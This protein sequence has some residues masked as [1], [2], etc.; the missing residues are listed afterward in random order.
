VKK[1]PGIVTTI[2]LLW[3]SATA[4]GQTFEIP[5]QSSQPAQKSPAAKSRTKPAQ[6]APESGSIGWGNSIEVGRTARAAEDAMKRGNFAAAANYAQR[7][8]QEAPGNAKLWFLLGY[9]S[10]MAGQISQSV[11]AYRK[12]LAREPNSPDGLSGLAQTYAKSGNNGEA[13]RIL[14]QVTNANPK[15]VNDLL[16]LGE[17]YIKINDLQQGVQVLQRA[18]SQ[19]PSAHSELLMAMAYMRLKEPD[20]A[21]QLLDAAKRRAPNNPEIF[22]A[23]A[24]Y[25]REEHDYKGAIETLKSVPHPTPDVWAD[26]GYSYELEGDK[27]EAANAYGQAANAQP[28]EIKFQLSAAQANLNA[29][30]IDDGKRYLARAAAIDANSYRLHA[31]RAALAKSEDRKQD[32]INE[33]NFALAHMSESVPEGQLYPI[34]LR[35]NLA[36]L[37][38]E[39]GDDSNAQQ[40]L[41]IAEQQMAR[42]NVEGPAKAEFLRVRA[43]IKMSRQDYAGAETDLKDALGID[44]NNTNARLQ[45]GSLLWKVGRKDEAKK[46][47]ADVLARDPNNRYAMESLGYLA[48]DGGDIKLAEEWFNKLATAYPTDYVPHLA[49]GDL[50][51]A[52]RDFAKAEDDYQHAY[53]LAPKNAI[54][55]ANAANAAIEARKFDSAGQWLARA[56]GDMQN[57]PKVMLERERYLFHVGKFAE[58]AELG[59]KVLTQLP[60]DRNASVYLGYALYDLGRYDDVLALTAKYANVLPKEPNF[61]LLAGHVHKQSQLLDEA[62]DDYTHAIERDPKMVEAYINRGYVYNDL[63]NAEQA[64]EDFDVALKLTPNNGIA[65]LGLAFADLQLHKGKSAL[66]HAETAAKLMGDSGAVHLARATAYRQMRLLDKAEKEYEVALKYAP[67]DLRLNLALADTLY[68]LRRYNDSLKVL[69]TAMTLSPD[70][71][72]I[73][74][75]MAHATAELH[76][77][78]RTLQYVQQAERAGADQSSVLLATG[79]ALL[80]LGDREGAMQRFSRALDT[81]DADKVDVRLAIARVFVKQGKWDDAKQQIALAFAESRIGEAAPVTADNLIEAANTFLAMN[82]FDLAR[83][84]YTRA[85][86]MGASDEVVA[87]GLANTYL[88]TGHSVDALHQLETLGSAADNQESYDYTLALANVYRQQHDNVR[89]LTALARANQLGGEDPVAERELTEVAGDEGLRLND[90]FSVLTN[91]DVAPI[92]DDETIYMLDAKLF[93]VVNSPSQL[94]PPRSSTQMA[95]TNAYRFHPGGLPTV[96]GFFQIRNSRGQ[97]S[98]PSEAL[99]LDRNTTDYALNSGINPV[100]HLGRNTVQ[101]NTGLQFTVRRDA[102]SKTAA[103]E[104]NQNLFRQFLYVS[105]NSFFNW[106]AVRGNAF[107]ESGPFT[108]RSLN[109]R[110]LGARLEFVVGRPWGR[111]YMVTGYSNRDL[112]FHPLVREFFSTSTY[113]GIEHRFGEHLKLT[114]VGEYIRSWRVQDTSWVF[115]QAMRPA[116]SLQYQPTRR[117]LVDAD[118]AF[119]RGQGFHAYDNMHSGFFIS[120]TKPLRKS[121][122]DGSGSVPVEYPLQFSV[123][124][125]QEQFFQFTG[126]GQAMFR[127]VFRLT[128]F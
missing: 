32:A 91:F 120:Y 38:R 110:D 33:Y 10:R 29:G 71:P 89:A 69:N 24:N 123:G 64:T 51:T 77:R 5:G 21:K 95:W 41:A 14:Q 98:V 105:T 122:A 79:D 39:N 2:L 118:F 42:I 90:K 3:L 62:I 7:A 75:E 36:D 55:V 78:A 115:A 4:A 8:A 31:I 82:D 104:L 68:H 13:I 27:K 84:Y 12:G 48:R 81:P 1:I 63:Q 17:L 113:A 40:Q 28:G 126:H 86:D 65:H 50:H 109:S 54:V 6:A 20:K 117:W 45:Y 61:P 80:T 119:T 35:M 57:E 43:S 59:K 16:V 106:I 121:I 103:A 49:L 66:D 87:I 73:Y 83:K 23:V 46:M 88:A 18:E 92:F 52:T 102:A 116:I 128:L 127:P 53:K 94:P 100:L 85:R 58:S 37:Y 30:T 74:A 19:Q 114:G 60:T 22:R 56:T 108:N 44:A 11:D 34:L 96:S 111:T 124:L 25:Y 26:L 125:Q 67:D 97:Y 15:R 93:G 101:F 72:L 70:D 107:H 112:L 76:D 47:Y 9:T 99:I